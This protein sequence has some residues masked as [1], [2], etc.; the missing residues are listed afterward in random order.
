[1]EVRLP[2][3]GSVATKARRKVGS[4][5]SQSDRQMP[6]SHSAGGCHNQEVFEHRDTLGHGG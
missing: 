3:G 2:L 4:G 6:V 1:M 5:K